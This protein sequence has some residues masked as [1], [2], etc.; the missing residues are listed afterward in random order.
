HDELAALVGPDI[1]ITRMDADTTNTKG[2][3]ERLLG[4]FAAAPTGVLLGT[5]MIAKGLDYPDVTLVGVI[6]ADTSLNL[7][8]FRAPERTYQLLEQVSGRA[9]RGDLPGRV[10]VQTYWADHP[11]IQAAAKHDRTSF[12]KA[13]CAMRESLSYPPFARLANV[14]VW[15]RDKDA[16]A[17]EARALGESIGAL[18]E[19]RGD[20][21]QLLGPSP[22]VLSRLR[23][24][25]RWHLLIKAPLDAHLAA[26]LAPVFKARKT[27]EGISAAIDI[28]PYNLL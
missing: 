13:E 19:S 10:V 7:P 23:G 22:C 24:V 18:I 5:Q 14:L 20:A 1:P 11:A 26:V 4:E 25:W 6:N 16:V 15:G 17:R 3:H 21:W 27:V 2:A 28:D 9:G 8:D 12:L